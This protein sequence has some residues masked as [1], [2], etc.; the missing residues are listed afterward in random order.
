MFSNVPDFVIQAIGFVGIFFNL[1]AVQ[2]NSHGKIVFLRT[3]GSVMFGIQ[4][5]FLGAIPGLVV[6]IIGWIRNV[7]FI[8]T[9]KKG[10]NTKFWIYFFS[11]ITIIA[12][13]TTM[14]LSWKTSIEKIS[15]WSSNIVVC[16]ILAVGISVIAIVAKVLSTVAYGIKN[17]DTIR[18]LNI[19]T[20]SM[21]LFYNFIAFSIAGI[22]NE[23]ITIISNLIAQWR[24]RKP[25]Q[26][27]IEQTEQK[28]ENENSAS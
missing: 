22:I 27:N 21:W 14:I 11:V 15:M 23:A 6:E 3:L 1:I 5:L 10:K 19:P 9:V 28:K 24:Y 18:K 25:K 16:T 12:G 4:Y 7:V 8:Y 2:F 17:P 20:S 26:K 13:V